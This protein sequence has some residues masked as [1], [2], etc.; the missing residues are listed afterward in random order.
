VLCWVYETGVW[1]VEV[2]LW[3]TVYLIVVVLVLLSVCN[4]TVFG[5]EATLFL[6]SQ[7]P[8]STH[9]ILPPSLSLSLSLSIYL[10]I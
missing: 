7:Q 10:Y 3:G 8:H 5:L 6:L 2:Y 1:C 9:P 4:F